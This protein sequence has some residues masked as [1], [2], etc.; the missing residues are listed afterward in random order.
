MAKGFASIHPI[1]AKNLQNIGIKNEQITQGWGT[2]VVASAGYHDPEGWVVDS[3]GRHRYSSC[4]DLTASL[5]FTPELKSRLVA[6][7]FCPFFRDW[8]GNRHIHGVYCG[9][10]TIKDGPKSQIVD[11]ING[12]NGLVGHD[13]L[14][15]ELAPTDAEKK[16]IKAAYD[17]SDGHNTVKVLYDEKEVN[18]YAFMGKIPGKPDEITRCELRPFIEFFNAKILDGKYLL[19]NGKT[20]DFTGC[21]PKLEGQFTRVDLRPIAN[22]LNLNIDKF[23]MSNGFGT[24]TLVTIEE[25]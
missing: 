24:A 18:C 17:A 11:Y 9:F 14:T 22:L 8:T 1:M 10:K 12:K 20:L 13:K 16:I 15:G 2:T 25:T 21:N 6:A 7:G 3:Y 4:V 23:V 19:Y 5:G